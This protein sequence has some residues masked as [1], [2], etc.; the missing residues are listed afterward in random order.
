VLIVKPDL[1]I[2][3]WITDTSIFKPNLKQLVDAL[4]ARLALFL[5]PF[6]CCC[7]FSIV[8]L[9]MLISLMGAIQILSLFLKLNCC[10]WVFSDCLLFV[11]QQKTHF[12]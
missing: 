10:C 7:S 11:N 12:N 5:A 6:D 9:I 3:E 2:I 1:Q 4:E 8:L